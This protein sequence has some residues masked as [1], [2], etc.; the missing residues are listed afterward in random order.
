MA[1]AVQYRKSFG[2]KFEWNGVKAQLSGTECFEIPCIPT[3]PELNTARNKMRKTS[4]QLNH[5]SFL[6]NWRP[7]P[8]LRSGNSLT[9]SQSK[10][11]L[12]Q[13]RVMNPFPPIRRLLK[14]LIFSVFL[15]TQVEFGNQRI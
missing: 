1:A 6:P 11:L 2:A 7:S 10:I 8:D 14:L 9:A 4:P 3:D 13:F 15:V 5:L 12:D